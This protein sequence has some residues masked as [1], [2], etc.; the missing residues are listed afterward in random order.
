M[1]TS[2]SLSLSKSI[3]RNQEHNLRQ[4]QILSSLAKDGFGNNVFRT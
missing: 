2:D 1:V 3:S 4:D